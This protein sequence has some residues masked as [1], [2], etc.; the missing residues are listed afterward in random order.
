VLL[1]SSAASLFK[2]ICRLLDVWDSSEEYGPGQAM[3]L[4]GGILLALK[5]LVH[6]HSLHEDFSKFG[7]SIS[8]AIIAPSSAL[9]KP[10]SLRSLSSQHQKLVASWITAF[11][12][13]EGIE[14]DLIRST[15]PHDMLLLAPTIVHQSVTAM[16]NG[17]IDQESKFFTLLVQ[18]I[19]L[20]EHAK[21]HYRMAFP[22]SVKN[23]LPLRCR[24]SSVTWLTKRCQIYK[25]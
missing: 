9:A 20:A 11:Y 14:D 8:S 25:S 16:E 2:P 22:T 15:S 13:S 12:G 19:A 21:Q 3:E 24:G 17:I 4:Y 10:H 6:R 18:I 23:S 7:L 5:T 1:H